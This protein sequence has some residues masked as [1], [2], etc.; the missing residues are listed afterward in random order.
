MTQKRNLNSHHKPTSYVKAISIDKG[1]DPETLSRETGIDSK[2]SSL[3][4]QHF[5]NLGL[6][7][8]ALVRN[9]SK[10]NIHH[11]CHQERARIIQVNFIL[12]RQQCR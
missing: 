7:Y 12:V 3:N 5:R 4:L 11:V 8:L 2:S 10:F 9:Q 1:D 6:L